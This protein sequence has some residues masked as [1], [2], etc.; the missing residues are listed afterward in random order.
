MI[1]Q[2]PKRDRPTLALH[3]A[4]ITRMRRRLVQLTSSAV[5]GTWLASCCSTLSSG[6]SA[7][8]LQDPTASAQPDDILV[9]G[10][11]ILGTAVACCA[12][13]MGARVTLVERGSCGCEASGLSAGTLWNAGC[14]R[15]VT[16]LSVSAYLRAR[17]TDMLSQLDGC[18]FNQS[19]A[20]EV[21]STPEEAAFLRSQYNSYVN[22]GLVCEW[23]VGQQ[24][25]V[26]VEPAL[27]GGSAC[28]AVR[29]ACNHE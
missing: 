17:S 26:A 15:E 6:Q 27:A 16:P 24:A 4:V 23:I 8:D 21:A 10:G 9:I 19:G 1:V 22:Q 28:C 3:R 13:R 20:L 14:P 2:K 29:A 5:A 25:V 11:G 12:S 7:A 18:E